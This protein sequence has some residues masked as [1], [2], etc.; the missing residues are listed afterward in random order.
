M[1]VEIVRQSSFNGGELDPRMRGRRDVKAYYSML[2]TALNL[3]PAPTGGINQRP[4]F[5]FVDYVRRQL[6]EIPVTA[7]MLTSGNAANPQYALPGDGQ[8]LETG[9]L[10]DIELEVVTVDFG[11]PVE[12]A[13]IDVVDYGVKETTGTPV[14]PAEPPFVYPYTPPPTTPPHPGPFSPSFGLGDEP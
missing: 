11:Q 8:V 9:N 4:G 7:A 10:I 13:L 3:I 2:E 1:P 12:V 6:E 14:D 5:S